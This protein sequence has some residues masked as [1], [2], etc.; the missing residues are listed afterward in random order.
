MS[1]H[2]EPDPHGE[3]QELFPDLFWVQG[4]IKM[5]PGIIISRNMTILRQNGELTLVSAVRLN[6]SGEA[7]LAELGVIKHTFP[8]ET[9]SAVAV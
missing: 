6:P 9:F 2:P 5:G 4:S 7:A 1:P 3:I 8:L